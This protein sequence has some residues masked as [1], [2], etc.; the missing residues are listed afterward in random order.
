MTEGRDMENGFGMKY[1]TEMHQA[2][3]RTE[4]DG[5]KM[6]EERRNAQAQGAAD[7]E[8]IKKLVEQSGVSYEDA[9]DALNACKGD[10]LDA[11]IYLEALGKTKGP[12]QSAYST[13]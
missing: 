6:E 11:M 13:L 3:D 5:E 4:R 10:I 8:Q 2:D 9:R 7:A 1:E 12:K